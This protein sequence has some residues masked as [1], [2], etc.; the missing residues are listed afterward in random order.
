MSSTILS[1]ICL[2]FVALS[3]S[4][5]SAQVANIKTESNNPLLNQAVIL[6]YHHISSTTPPST[7]ASPEVFEEHLNLIDRLGF[8]VRPLTEVIAAIKAGRPFEDKT[9]AIT[10]DD[11]YDSIYLEG[12]PRLKAR[13]WPFTVFISPRAI[14]K[15]HGSTMSWEQ[16][17]EMQRN[18][19]TIANHSLQHLHLLERL[20]GENQETWQQ[21]IRNDIQQAQTRLKETLNIDNQLFAY[22]YGEFDEHLKRLLSE[23][24]YIAFSQQSGP[25]NQYSDF[26]S[27]PRF[28]A[29]GIYAN[30][31]TLETK[32][33]SL[34]FNIKSV[35]PEHKIRSSSEPAPELSI[36][37]L[38]DDV[39]Y[40]Q[41]QCFY[42]GT[43]IPT[44][45]TKQGEHVVLT[46]QFNGNLKTGRSRYNCTA[47][48][49]SMKRYYWYSMPFITLNESNSWQD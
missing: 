23:E 8:Q 5:S 12:Y 48:S 15:N 27:L 38:A 13:N 45:T 46:A 4:L 20:S 6:Q 3:S 1:A 44:A 19:A 18:G 22:P 9:V 25:V 17:N 33:N 36:T 16:L 28:P 35:T 42:A 41:T 26:Q 24:G 37:V 31:K 14:D 7:S 32:L 11:G 40:Q 34:A 43:P 2:T 30:P 47:P 10:F 39:R 21:R 29:S 49:K